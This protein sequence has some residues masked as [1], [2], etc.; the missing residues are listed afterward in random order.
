MTDDDRS[1]FIRG[2]GRNSARVRNPRR[3][4][5]LEDS[6]RPRRDIIEAGIALCRRALERATAAR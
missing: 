5:D 6:P 3:V 1:Q 2:P 4:T